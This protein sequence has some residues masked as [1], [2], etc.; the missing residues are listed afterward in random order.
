M[1]SQVSKSYNNVAGVVK[2]NIDR[3]QI[4]KGPKKQ[5]KHLSLNDRDMFSSA[6]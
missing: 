1:N 6:I 4:L 3:I 5:T 2:L